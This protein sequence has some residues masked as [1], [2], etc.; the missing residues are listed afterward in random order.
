MENKMMD[1]LL[2]VQQSV[3]E[4]RDDV[5]IIKADVADLKVR[6]TNIEERVTSIEE[7]MVRKSDL[8]YYDFKIAEHDREIFQLKQQN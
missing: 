2:Q 1:I 5:N 8:K 3:L 6:M 4:L 7:N